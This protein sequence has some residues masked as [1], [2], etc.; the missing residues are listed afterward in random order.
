MNIVSNHRSCNMHIH[1]HCHYI[2]KNGKNYMHTWTNSVVQV[3]MLSLSLL[4]NPLFPLKSIH[5][6][7]NNLWITCR[8]SKPWLAV[9]ALPWWWMPLQMLMK[10]NV[11]V[12][13]HWWDNG[14]CSDYNGAKAARLYYHNYDHHTNPPSAIIWYIPGLDSYNLPNVNPFVLLFSIYLLCCQCIASS[15]LGL[16]E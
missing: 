10:A 1:F 8:C 9:S 2:E 6:P 7:G 11:M 12:E 5:P 16:L 13:L 15:T 4:I 14:T 3:P